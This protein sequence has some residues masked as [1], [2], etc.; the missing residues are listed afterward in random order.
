KMKIGDLIIVSEGNHKFRAIAEI[1]GDYT[2]LSD[3]NETPDYVQKRAVKW[4]KIFQPSLSVEHLF[5]K[6]LSQQTLYNLANAINLQKIKNILTTKSEIDA[7]HKNFVLIIDEINRGNIS[8]IFGELITLIEDT[9]RQGAEEELSV[10]LPYSKE[11][12]SV[13]NNV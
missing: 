2:V 5:D 7:Q 10:T 3:E 13:P 8:R 11:E 12:F 1:T 6:I 4:L 9:K